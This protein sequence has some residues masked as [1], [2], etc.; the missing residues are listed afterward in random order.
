[1]LRAEIG[2]SPVQ[3]V[4]LPGLDGTGIL[5]EPLLR[6]LGPGVVPVVI[7]YPRDQ[8]LGYTELLPRVMNTLAALPPGEPFVLLGESFGGPL[9]MRIAASKPA[10]LC[11]LILSASFVSCPQAWAANW[12]APLVGA[13]PFQLF[14]PYTRVKE[15]LGGY[16]DAALARLSQQAIAEVAPHVF[17][18]RVREVIRVDARADLAACDLPMLY[19][20]GTHDRVV[21]AANL[22]RIL[23]IKPGVS[24]ARLSAPHMVLQTQAARAAQ[25]IRNFVTDAIARPRG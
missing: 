16:A 21:P 24:V 19:I 18:H 25:V 6:E 3:L 2:T 5:F 12:S 14:A 13:W 8:A 10:G 11:A 20:Q 23:R 9:A 7:D 15:I 1:M 4:L 17:A 22:Q